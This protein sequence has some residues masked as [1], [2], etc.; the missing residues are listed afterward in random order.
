MIGQVPCILTATW[1]KGSPSCLMKE[2]TKVR[3]AQDTVATVEKLHRL[4]DLTE[5]SNFALKAAVKKST[6]KSQI[7]LASLDSF[8]NYSEQDLFGSPNSPFYDGIHMG[9]RHGGQAHTNCIVTAVAAAGL[10]KN[11]I[12]TPEISTSNRYKALSN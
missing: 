12:T 10:S 9:G 8:Y 1:L 3:T 5:F 4:A 2:P 11:Q 6:L 7:S